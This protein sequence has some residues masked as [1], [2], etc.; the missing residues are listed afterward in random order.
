L[1][2]IGVLLESAN[3]YPELS[4]KNNLRISCRIKG[5]DESMIEP[6]LEKMNLHNERRTKVKKFSLGMKQRLA[7]ASVLLGEPQ[8]LIFDEPTN[9]LDPQGIAEMRRIILEQAEEGRTIIVAS[10]LLN[11]ME[12]VCTHVAI[13]KSGKVLSSG[14]LKVLTQNHSSLEDYF[15]TITK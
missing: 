15:L 12:K 9:G 7:I 3:Y 4:A 1:K 2:R 14:E 11:E 5:V 8:L 6:V 13:M 10:H